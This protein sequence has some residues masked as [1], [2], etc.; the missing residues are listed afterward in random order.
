LSDNVIYAFSPQGKYLNHFSSRGSN[1]D[2]IEVDGQGQIYVG[3]SNVVHVLTPDGQFVAD[4]P[5]GVFVRGMAMDEKGS[6]W[7]VSGDKV[8]QFYRVSNR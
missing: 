6:L 7:V 4:F 5:A 8:T 3:D 2:S 1:P